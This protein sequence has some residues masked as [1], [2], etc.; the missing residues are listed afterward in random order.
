MIANAIS[1]AAKDTH[2]D[3]KSTHYNAADPATASH[4]KSA[5]THSANSLASEHIA[6]QGATSTVTE[7]DAHEHKNHEHQK[8]L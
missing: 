3:A 2:T 7:L 5:T 1:G 6:K 4:N 8:A